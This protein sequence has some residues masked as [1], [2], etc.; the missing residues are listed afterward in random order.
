[1]FLLCAPQ[2]TRFPPSSLV[3][4]P[5]AR[6]CACDTIFSLFLFLTT[7]HTCI[8]TSLLV[9]ARTLS[10]VLDTGFCGVLQRHTKVVLVIVTSSLLHNCC[11]RSITMCLDVTLLSKQPCHKHLQKQ[12]RRQN[13]KQTA[14]SVTKAA[15]NERRVVWWFVVEEV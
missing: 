5:H 9:D 11:K 7:L 3:Y 10:G 8:I 12:Q 6:V 2:A 1:M 13:Q 14:V 4:F 15:N